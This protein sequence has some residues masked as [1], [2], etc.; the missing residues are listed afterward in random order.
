MKTSNFLP[1]SPETIFIS[2]L[3]D[4]DSGREINFFFLIATWLL[5]SSKWQP[6]QKKL[7]AIFR[8]KQNLFLRCQHSRETLQIK[9]GERSLTCYKVDTR[10]DDIQLSSSPKFKMASSYQSRCMCCFLETNLTR[11]FAVDLSLQIFL[12]HDISW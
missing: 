12:I 11:K 9:L 1:N 5:N 3:D 4:S 8:D 6:I 10:R 7:V 2:G